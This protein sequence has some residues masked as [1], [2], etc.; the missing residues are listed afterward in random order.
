[1]R[2]VRDIAEFV[3]RHWREKD[4]DERSFAEIAERALKEVQSIDE[5][6][7]RHMFE[8]AAQTPA[9]PIQKVQQ[10][11]SDF[12]LQLFDG[13]RFEIEMY[14]WIDGT[15][16]IHDHTFHGAFKVVVGSS[17]QSKYSFEEQHRV[18]A[19]FRVGRLHLQLA[20]LLETGDVR[21]V[22]PAQWSHSLFHLDRPSVTLIVKTKRDLEHSLS[23][24]Y[25][26][27]G[28]A[29]NPH[30]IN[31][32]YIR[33]SHAVRA[34]YQVE[35]EGLKFEEYLADLM[36]NSDFYAAARVL[37]DTAALTGDHALIRRMVGIL[38]QKHGSLVQVEALEEIARAE[39]IAKLRREVR[40]KDHRFFVA[41]LMNVPTW[42]WVVTLI[43]QRFPERDAHAQALSWLKEIV[44]AVPSIGLTPS[45]ITAFDQLLEGAGAP[46]IA[47][48]VQASGGGDLPE[49]Q[50]AKLCAEVKGS[51]LLKPLLAPAPAAPRAARV[52]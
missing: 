14:F 6:K 47:K 17:I 35:V 18:S 27:P 36:R 21:Q 9:L 52:A 10:T 41:L 22:N 23:F 29:V 3:E 50:V 15:T 28:I 1:M 40:D 19:H 51:Y 26:K 34:L 44:T 4:Y 42:D 45:H 38:V 20:E 48:A 11:F 46:E 25:N 30:L 12:Q 37:Q 13:S 2:F 8:W 24:I 33:K 39:W 5:F 32:E 49:A 16:E 7:P 31:Q 43:K